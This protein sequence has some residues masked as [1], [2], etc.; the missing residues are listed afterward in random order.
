MVTANEFIAACQGEVGTH[1]DP[2]GSNRTR[3]AALAGHANG[4]FW[5]HTFLCGVARELH[6]PVPEAVL[7]TAYTPSGVAAWKAVNRWFLTPHPGDWGYIDFP[8]DSV[9]R[10]SHCAVI[11]A[12]H[13]DGTVTTVEGNTSIGTSGSQRD[14]IWVAQRRRNRGLFKGYGRPFYNTPATA[15]AQRTLRRGVK[16]LDVVYWQ[17]CLN[18]APKER[19]GDFGPRTEAKTI[20]FQRA[21]SLPQDGVVGPR[22]WKA[23]QDLL[24]WLGR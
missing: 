16:G 2:K 9:Y 15:G 6:A 18:M 23:M 10:V 17:G 21:A 24:A 22:T 4:S 19:D 8:G 3:Y 12:V 14:G 7:R 13:S 20:A 1:E 5:C 11:V